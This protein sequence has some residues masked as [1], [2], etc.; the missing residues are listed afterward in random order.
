MQ[1]FLHHENPF[2]LFFPA[3]GFRR[4]I[5]Q[6]KYTSALVSKDFTTM[7]HFPLLSV[8][9]AIINAHKALNIFCCST[10]RLAPKKESLS[11]DQTFARSIAMKTEQTP[12]YETLYILSLRVVLSR[13]SGNNSSCRTRSVALR[14]NLLSASTLERPKFVPSCQSH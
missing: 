2:E 10:A 6:F 3:L 4:L 13:G 9:I 5:Y 7:I 8:C 12:L 11:S 1:Q 14:Q